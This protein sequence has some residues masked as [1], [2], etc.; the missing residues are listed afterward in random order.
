M[1]NQ[2]GFL[3]PYLRIIKGFMDFMGF[4]IDPFSVFVVFTLLGNL[5]DIYFRIEIGCKRFTMVSRVTV[6]DVEIMDL[7]EM[8]FRCVCEDRGYS[9]SNP[10]PGLPSVRIF[11]VIMVCPCQLYSNFASSGGS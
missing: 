6:D 7:V 4:S 10:Q 11:A 1:V 5:P 3:W 2:V 9:G 8:V